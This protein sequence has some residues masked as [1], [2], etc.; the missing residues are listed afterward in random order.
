[1][2]TLFHKMITSVAILIQGRVGWG[3]S[4]SSENLNGQNQF[5]PARPKTCVRSPQIILLITSLRFEEPGVSKLK[6][7]VGTP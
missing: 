3:R 7:R 6:L 4:I 1:M 2:Q 5:S